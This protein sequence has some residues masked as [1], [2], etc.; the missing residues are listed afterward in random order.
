MLI[1]FWLIRGHLRRH[2]ASSF[3][4][5]FSLAALFLGTYLT[6]WTVTLNNHVIA[7]ATGL[8]A[9]HAMIRIFY[10]GRRECYWFVLVGLCGTLTAAV[11]LPAG[12]LAAALI[13]AIFRND[14]RRTLAAA[15]PPALIVT[16]VALYTN[17]Q[18]MGSIWPAYTEVFKPGGCYDYPGSYWRE[19][20]GIDALDEPK[21]LYLLNLLVG[22][23]GFF[24]LTPVIVLCL[25]GLVR[26][27]AGG[28]YAR[29]GLAALVLLLTAAVTAVYVCKTNNYGGLCEGPRWLF[30]L[31]PLW[32]LFL[33]DGTALLAK[34]RAGR[35]MCYVFLAVSVMSMA[36][37]LPRPWSH[38]W[39]HRLFAQLH[40]IN[41]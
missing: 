3:V 40:W 30:W 18:V 25:L 14:W 34:A 23:H 17:Y 21:T 41:Y 27:L 4:Y 10:D 22:H 15:V 19:P 16:A 29:R 2:Q 24:S 28:Q 6:A 31:V 26:H 11:E 32:L 36:D 9:T 39:L 33:A 35:L 13:L 5:G 7:A 12:L 1:A 20:T 38:S 37:A 8:F